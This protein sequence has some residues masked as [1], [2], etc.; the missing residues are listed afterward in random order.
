[1]PNKLR[2]L[3]FLSAITVMSSA[4]TLAPTEARATTPTRFSCS[5]TYC[6]PWTE[7][8]SFHPGWDCYMEPD[9]C[10]VDVRCAPE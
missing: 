10:A 4:L 1:M 7:Y 6:V 5:G 3:G 2:L 8:C 9:G